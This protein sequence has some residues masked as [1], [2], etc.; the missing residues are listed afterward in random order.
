MYGNSR[1]TVVLDKN[2]AIDDPQ[3][4]YCTECDENYRLVWSEER[5][6]VFAVCDCYEAENINKFLHRFLA[7]NVDGVSVPEESKRMYQ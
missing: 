5:G 3:I 6:E 7:A 2:I 4:I 1:S